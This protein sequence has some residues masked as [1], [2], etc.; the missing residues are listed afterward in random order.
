[1][2]PVASRLEV[3]GN[4]DLAPFTGGAW[5]KTSFTTTNRATIVRSLMARE[6]LPKGN[7]A[8]SFARLVRA[9]Q[10]SAG[11]GAP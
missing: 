10:V 2:A 3:K 7:C 9:A 11:D 8:P 6:M 4:I 1:M 5:T